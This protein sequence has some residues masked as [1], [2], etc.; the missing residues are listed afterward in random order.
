LRI[1]DIL[2]GRTRPVPSRLD[3]LFAISTAY[4]TLTA[5]LGLAS[6]GSAGVCFRPIDS[7]RFE[8]LGADLQGI[9]KISGEETG[10]AI[11]TATDS[12]GFQWVTV[13]SSDF[14]ELVSTIHLVSLTLEE[15]GF[16]D[17]L[18]AAV[19]RFLDGERPVYWV[20][21][22]KRGN[23]YPFAPGGAPGQRDNARE[24]RLA[25][26]MGRELPVEREIERWYPL[27][28]APV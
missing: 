20:Y 10:A 4:L 12:Y 25:A 18:L 11:R 26:A 27:W 16:G 7:A 14:Q 15:R 13:E 1:L 9:L 6:G 21:S 19:F 8:A 3:S 22:Y 24:L 2:L 5:D 23:F 17:R 28:G